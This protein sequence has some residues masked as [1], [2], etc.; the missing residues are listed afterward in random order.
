MKSGVI[1]KNIYL[2]LFIFTIESQGYCQIRY[3][4]SSDTLISN[5]NLKTNHRNNLYNNPYYPDFKEKLPDGYWKLYYDSNDRKDTSNYNLI[6][7]GRFVDS[8]RQGIFKIYHFINLYKR[9]DRNKKEL[10][11]II[12]YKDNLLNGP[13]YLYDPNGDLKISGYYSNGKR[14]GYF[15]FY[16]QIK[17]NGLKHLSIKEVQFFVNDTLLQWQE[18]NNNGTIKRSGKG[19]R[20]SLNGRYVEFD[21]LGYIVKKAVF[22]RGKLVE[23]SEYYNNGIIKRKVIGTFKDCRT[24]PKYPSPI[25]CRWDN[26][27]ISLPIDGKVYNFDKYGK[28]LIVEIYRHGVKVQ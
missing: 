4:F 5:Y 17:T 27:C 9:K 2:I 14:N 7:E 6:I 1:L 8:M 10:E 12:Y 11:A 24:F 18:F 26:I 3:G 25:P 20:Y 16:H 22:N 23:I 21:S 15:V 19:D 28:L 13:F